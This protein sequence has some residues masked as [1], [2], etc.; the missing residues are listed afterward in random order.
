[1]RAGACFWLGALGLVCAQSS[2]NISGDRPVLLWF[3]LGSVNKP[4]AGQGSDELQVPFY[5]PSTAD[6]GHV[7]LPSWKVAQPSS[8][9]PAP[10]PTTQ[11]R[12]EVTCV[13]T[14]AP[15]SPWWENLP[16]S[17]IFFH[18]FLLNRTHFKDIP[19]LRKQQLSLGTE[20]V[21]STEIPPEF[22]T[23]HP[24]GSPPGA[25]GP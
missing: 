22:S 13:P 17:L 4:P 2:A 15:P 1:M 6:L 11:H 20:P 9:K 25:V 16:A 3:G 7:M 5:K 12:G 18:Q 10:A 23:Q 8:L 19:A 24:P 14:P 21:G